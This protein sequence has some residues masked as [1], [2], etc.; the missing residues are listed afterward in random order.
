MQTHARDTKRH[1]R[2]VGAIAAILA[3]AILLVFIAQYRDSVQ[4]E[5]SRCPCWSPA[6]DPEGQHRRRGRQ[7]EM[8]TGRRC[9]P[10]GSRTARSPT[11]TRLKGKVA[12]EDIYP[13]EQLTESNFTA[14]DGSEVGTKI[15]EYERAMA[16]P[17]DSAHGMIGDV[18]A[19]DHVDVSP[20][21]TSQRIRRQDSIRS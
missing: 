4:Q 12:A 9:R 17:L 18:Q 7:Q 2:L 20:A 13:G 21:S 1:D 15:T 5:Q 3:A 14:A 11:P 16:I 6:A 8:Y 19:G 10:T